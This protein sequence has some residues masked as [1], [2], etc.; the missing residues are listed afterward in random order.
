MWIVWA[1]LVGLVIGFIARLLTPGKH[2][3]GVIV[4]MVVGIAGSV[5]A[6]IGGRAAGFYHSGE[7]AG[8]IASIVGAI[9]LLLVLQALSGNRGRRW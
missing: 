4:T 5:I 3:S 8:F 6:T 1:A 9:V 2:P 7:R